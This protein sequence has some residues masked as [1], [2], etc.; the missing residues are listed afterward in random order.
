[1]KTALLLLE[2]QNDYFP[3][4]GRIPLEKSI[5]ASTKARLVLDHYRENNLPI[6]H[7][8]HISFD[9]FADRFLPCTK[10]AEFYSTVHPKHGEIIVKKHYPNS[11][12]D[13]VLRSYLK[14]KKINHLMICGMMTQTTVD[15]T[16]KAAYD[17]GYSCTVVSDACAARH[18]EFNNVNISA[19]NVHYAFLAA[20]Q[21]V[22]CNVISSDEFKKTGDRASSVVAATA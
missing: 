13:T 6:I 20:L 16:V 1:M 14:E 22:Y 3:N 8:Q 18:L 15:A 10:G 2:I 19:Q 21:P 4:G 11:F 5:D 9:R 12:K 17:L 7:V